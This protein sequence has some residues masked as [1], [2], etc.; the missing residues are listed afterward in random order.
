M[1]KASGRFLHT[2]VES[3]RLDRLASKYYNQPDKWW[4]I[5]D[6]NPEFMQPQAMLGK[7]P[8][9]T[10]RFGITFPKTETV[11]P[12]ADLIRQLTRL[13]GVQDVWL[14]RDERSLF[15]T[16]NQMNLPSQALAKWIAS[17]LAGNE[18]ENA[19]VE[20]PQ[21]LGQIG[22]QVLIPPNRLE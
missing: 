16:F 10:Q 21:T 22:R 7:T 8:F 14:A 2:I 20:P 9:V 3:D 13:V 4:Q 11:P 19:K 12:W 15:V 18:V 5:C 17:I 6:A 1:S